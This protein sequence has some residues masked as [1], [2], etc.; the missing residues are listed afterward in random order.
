MKWIFVIVLAVLAF[1]AVGTGMLAAADPEGRG[2]II[3]L[4]TFIAAAVVL[5]ISALLIAVFG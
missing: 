1:L 4:A 2:G 5:I 3:G